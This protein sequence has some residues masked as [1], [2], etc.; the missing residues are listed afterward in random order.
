MKEDRAEAKNEGREES[1]NYENIQ[2][3]VCLLIGKAEEREKEKKRCVAGEEREMF[4]RGSGF[5]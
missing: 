3:Q 1:E 5:G 2:V 4:V